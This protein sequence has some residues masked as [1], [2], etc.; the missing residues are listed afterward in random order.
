VG[1][2]PKLTAT[3]AFQT[4]EEQEQGGPER[5]MPKAESKEEAGKISQWR[6]GC[7]WFTPA[8]I[9]ATQNAEIRRIMVS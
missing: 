3:P 5:G 8:V 4:P 6:A 9:L 7:W 2:T 1:N